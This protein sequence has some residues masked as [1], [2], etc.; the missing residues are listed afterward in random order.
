MFSMKISRI[1]IL[2]LVVPLFFPAYGQQKQT[3][4]KE[5]LERYKEKARELTSFYYYLLNTL[6]SEKTGAR[7]KEIIVTDSFK[8]YFVDEDVQV[9]DDLAVGREV[10][11]NKDID[12]YL[13]DVDFFF[14]DARFNYEIEDIAQEVNEEGNPYIKVHLSRRLSGV[15][16]QNDTLNNVQ[17]R[18]IEFNI[19][20]KDDELLIASIYTTKLSEKEDLINWWNEL[21]F[22]WQEIL[23][24]AAEIETDSVSYDQLQNIITLKKI[25]IRENLLINSIEPLSKLTDLEQLDMAH[26][27][28][29]DLAPLRNLTKIAFLNATNSKVKD[30]DALRY[31]FNLNSLFLDETKVDSIETIKNLSNLKILSLK[32]LPI[33]DL[34]PLKN[35]NKLEE[36]YLNETDIKTIKP[37]NELNSL[38]VLNISNTAVD[39]LPALNKLKNLKSLNISG[40]KINDLQTVQEL[41]NLEEIRFDNTPVNSLSALEELNHLKKIYSDYAGIS[42]QQA[43]AFMEHNPG[44]LVIFAS[45]Q[46]FEWWQNLPPEWKEALFQHNTFYN[47]SAPSKEELASLTRIDSLNL[48]DYNL[49][50][51]DPL[52]SFHNL[53]YL[54]ISNNEISDIE[55]LGDFDLRVVNISNNPI[56]DISTLT[57]LKELR[58]IR[59]NNLEVNSLTN[60]YGL[61]D[62]QLIFAEGTKID[63]EAVRLYENEHPNTLI[64]YKTQELKEWWAGLDAVWQKIFKINLTSD[65]DPK[66]YTIHQ[67]LFLDRIIIENEP[68]STLEPLTI[69]L[70]PKQILL[71]Q[72]NVAD[73][74]PLTKFIELEVLKAKQMPVHDLTPLEKIKNLQ[75]LNI[76]DTPVEDL[77]PLMELCQLRQLDLSS[78]QVKKIKPLCF[79]QNLRGLNIANTRVRKLKHLRNL[80]ALEELICYNTRI[81]PREVE[82]FKEAQPDCRVVYYR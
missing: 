51:L 67:L 23:K 69:L 63:D 38:R 25:D 30:I 72:L 31:A 7:E 78:T 34:S 64:V 8:K 71:Q 43:A 33:N 50:K 56:D 76:S 11:T 66:D 59:L 5:D 70:A 14:K 13:K 75:V 19:A 40:T 55:L 41:K 53:F 39:S 26:T 52:K 82:K 24:E 68:V 74:S 9:E 16:V 2:L 60:L 15:N 58:E 28:V 79:L 77:E 36:L 6:A 46:L 18:F 32:H 29:S 17:D 37:I 27:R 12:A 48:R 22:G 3:F 54:D 21:S 47:K 81:S 20:E 45:D 42:R 44:T 73:L 80:E 61:E 57:Q 4:S 10:P 49:Q 65:F 35:L 1:L 62:L